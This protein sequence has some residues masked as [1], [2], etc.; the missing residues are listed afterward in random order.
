MDEALSGLVVF[1]FVLYIVA[2]VVAYLVAFVA[3]ACLLYFLFVHV[4][5]PAC[6]WLAREAPKAAEALYQWYRDVTWPYRVKR[7]REQALAAIA[8]ARCEQVARVRR[9]AQELERYEESMLALEGGRSK[10]GSRRSVT[11]R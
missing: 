7:T 3:G 11:R 2:Y 1:F 10:Q 6:R 8:A 9:I 4:I 5:A